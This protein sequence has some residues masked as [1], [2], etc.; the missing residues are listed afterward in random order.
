MQQVTY[1]DITIKKRVLDKYWD[2]VED[3]VFENAPHIVVFKFRD[4]KEDYYV[5]GWFLETDKEVFVVL[6][7][8]EKI[9]D[10]R[11]L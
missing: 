1:G 10:M 3:C 4:P 8:S 9:E 5:M 2:V 6:R 7:E 11:V